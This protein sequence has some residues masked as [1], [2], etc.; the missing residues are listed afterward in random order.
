MPRP[1]MDKFIACLEAGIQGEEL[2]APSG[3]PA[4]KQAIQHQNQ[5]VG[6]S[7]KQ[8]IQHQNQ[9][10]GTSKLLQGYLARSWADALEEFGCKR[11]PSKILGSYDKYGIYCA[12]A[13]GTQEILFFITHPTVT[14]QRNVTTS[15]NG[16]VGIETIAT[17]SWPSQIINWQTTETKKSNT[18]AEKRDGSG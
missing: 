8:A 17:L 4:L 10:V 11:V 3:S 13:S 2:P 12:S 16:F 9:I 6:T 14:E 18:W 15:P 1:F 5:I 7:M